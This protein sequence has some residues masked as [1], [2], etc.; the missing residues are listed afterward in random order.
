[1]GAIGKKVL[2]RIYI[3]AQIDAVGFESLRRGYVSRRASNH[4][5]MPA[6]PVWIC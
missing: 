1:M 2:H 5:P 6:S 4:A 3:H